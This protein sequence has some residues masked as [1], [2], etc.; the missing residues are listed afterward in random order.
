MNAW[1]AHLGKHYESDTWRGIFI[2]CLG[3]PSRGS[4]AAG[5]SSVARGIGC[6]CADLIVCQSIVWVQISFT[7]V[8]WC[9]ESED[10]PCRKC[11]I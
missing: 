3:S 5:V 9:V 7:F 8:L 10:T 4:N 2:F 1:L 6:K 11:R